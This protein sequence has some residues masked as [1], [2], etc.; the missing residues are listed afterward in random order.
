MKNSFP[1]CFASLRIVHALPM[2]RQCVTWTA[3]KTAGSDRQLFRS[4]DDIYREQREFVGQTPPSPDMRISTSPFG[5]LH[6]PAPRHTFYYLISALN[7]AFPDYDFSRVKPEQFVR[8]AN[9]WVMQSKLDGRL[10][11]AMVDYESFRMQLWQML[12]LEMD[13]ERCE[14]FSLIPTGELGDPFAEE[15]EGSM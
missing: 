9:V 12:N 4:L 1:A 2:M 3:G 5:P 11:G 6:E 13:F 15:G 7:Q 14:V 10:R 8:E